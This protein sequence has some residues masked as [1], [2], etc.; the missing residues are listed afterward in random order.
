MI[1]LGHC[2]D[3]QRDLKIER[4]RR[5][6]SDRG[7][8][9]WMNASTRTTNG[10][11]STK[12]HG[13]YPTGNTLRKDGRSL[14]RLKLYKKAWDMSEMAESKTRVLTNFDEP[15]SNAGYGEIRENLPP[16]E[17]CNTLIRTLMSLYSQSTL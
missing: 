14:G 16:R 8:N 4:S 12:A 6:H 11:E 13:P 3:V 5:K 10:D 1:L 9:I 7:S 15:N 17:S 2:N